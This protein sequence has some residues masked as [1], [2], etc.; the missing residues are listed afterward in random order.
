MKS[1]S[2]LA[3]AILA[4]LGC[5]KEDEH[6]PTG[7]TQLLGA[8]SIAL[9]TLPSDVIQVRARITRNGFA[10]QETQLSGTTSGFASVPIGVWKLRVTGLDTSGAAIYSDQEDVDVQHL[11]VAL[12]TLDLVPFVTNG[13]FEIGPPVGTY[14][15]LDSGS[16]AIQNWTVSRGQLDYV[17]VWSS[18]HGKRSL[19]MHGTPGIGG[20]RQTITTIKGKTYQVRFALAGNPEGSPAI[21]TLGISAGGPSSQFIFDTT[22]R[23]FQNMGWTTVSWEFVALGTQTTLEFYSLSTTSTSYGPAIDNVSVAEID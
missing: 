17:T 13:S 22:G 8:I 2:I 4:V 11:L 6:S 9:Q 23:T 5:N 1:A 7:E 19:D 3:V 15:P 18:Y 12:A 14:L 10:T 16:T 20:I 21:K